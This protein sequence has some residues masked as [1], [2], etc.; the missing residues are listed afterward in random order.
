MVT[1]PDRDGD[2]QLRLAGVMKR[3]LDP[4]PL[5]RVGA[6][7]DTGG[8][9]EHQRIRAELDRILDHVA[10]GAGIRR[11][12][13]AFDAEQQVQDG[14]LAGIRFADNRGARSLP[15]QAAARE[16]VVQD[17]YVLGKPFE[18]GCDLVAAGQLQVLV[19]EIDLDLK[20]GLDADHLAT[21]SAHAMLERATELV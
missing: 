6:L 2:Q 9:L 15:H 17:S 12:D 5:D 4:D 7:A 16:A 19:A 13:G 8:I 21:Q 20:M 14:R 1:R 10:G 3:T 18:L 11:H